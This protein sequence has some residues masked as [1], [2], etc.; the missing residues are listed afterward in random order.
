MSK[1]G[2]LT[3]DD[4]RKEEMQIYLAERK[5]YGNHLLEKW[6]KVKGIG[7]GLGKLYSTDQERARNTA[8]QIQMQENHLT[9]LSET[10]ISQDFQ[11]TPE[12]VL[13]VV[14]IGVANSN[15]GAIFTE[16]PL[17]TIDDAIYFVD[18][19][20]G[21]SLRGATA[22]DKIYESVNQYYAGER[23][24]DNVGTGN[25]A[26][27]NFTTT[28]NKY[29]LI[30][31]SVRIMVAGKLIGND[32]GNGAIVGTGLSGTNTVD[33]ATGDIELTFASAVA[34]GDSIDAESHW[35]SERSTL[36]DQYG[37]VS[38]SVH[39]ERFKA[40]PM[41]L[42]YE[43][44]QM[45]ELTL[46]TT[47]LDQGLGVENMLM[48]AVGDEHAKSRDYKAIALAK[49]VALRNAVTTFNADF[50]SV[51]EVSTKSH[52]QSI[53]STIDD[54]GGDIYDDIKRGQV[55]RAV[56]GSR[57]LTY[58]KKHDLWS[59]DDTQPRSGVYYAGKLDDIEVFCCPKDNGLV[60]N[61]EVLLTYK[62][63]EEGMDLAL[64][65]GV[66]TEIVASLKY[67]QFYTVGNFATVEDDMIINDKFLRLL[68]ITNLP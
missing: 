3:E 54:I 63:P 16:Y 29:P 46:G 23:Q 14:R 13:R 17:R 31:Y 39:K 49:R 11:T 65:F 15:R 26:L 43:F 2:R 1:H 42:G 30:P 20:Y 18:A 59:T 22:G 41:P 58:L 4:Q 47:G 12:N 52:A 7:E 6:A 68:R 24:L 32:D 34:D 40:R 37:T 19:T 38:L 21:K 66:L 60:S 36:Y 25:G 27:T 28:A 5:S 51:G 33:Y 53:L 35:D 48:G 57:S 61:N 62:N 56:C 44:T 64:V 55:N 50:A 67:P 10:I 8:M 9:K 45:V